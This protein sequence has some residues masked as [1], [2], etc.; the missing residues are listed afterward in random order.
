MINDFEIEKIAVEN[1]ISKMEA[2][3]LYLENLNEYKGDF[4]K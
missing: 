4:E 2:R 3:L 1:N